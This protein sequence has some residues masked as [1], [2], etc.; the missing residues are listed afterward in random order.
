MWVFSANTWQN[1][2]FSNGFSMWWRCK[3]CVWIWLLDQK[4]IKLIAYTWARA[5]MDHKLFHWPKRRCGNKDTTQKTLSR[6]SFQGSLMKSWVH[7]LKNHLCLFY[8]ELL[9]ENINW[10]ENSLHSVSWVT[11]RMIVV[12][13]KPFYVHLPMYLPG[14]YAC[15]T[16]KTKL[17]PLSQATFQNY[18][19]GAEQHQHILILCLGWC[20]YVSKG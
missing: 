6:G 2:S 4:R 9:H 3:L 10:G 19:E 5:S 7:I 13:S 16:T 20:L 17:P 1:R 18:K 11:G 8:K 15:S 12:K 14:L